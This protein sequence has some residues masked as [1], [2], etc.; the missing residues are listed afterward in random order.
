MLI[1]FR[2][3]RMSN[4]QQIGCYAPPLRQNM[5]VQTSSESF[6]GGASEPAQP[7]DDPL[8]YGMET[9]VPR[10]PPGAAFLFRVAGSPSPQ[11]QVVLDAIGRAPG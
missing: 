4:S 10:D 5:T 2:T 1:S 7:E 6:E 9:R 8:A 3:C 11:G